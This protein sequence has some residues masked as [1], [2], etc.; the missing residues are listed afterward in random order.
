MSLMRFAE[1]QQ[2]REDAVFLREMDERPE[3]EGADRPEPE[4]AEGL[5]TPPGDAG[6]LDRHEALM[7]RAAEVAEASAP[8]E[9]PPVDRDEPAPAPKPSVPPPA[10]EGEDA[11]DA[12]VINVPGGA[13]DAPVTTGSGGASDVPAA[14]PPA[15]AGGETGMPPPAGVPD[16]VAPLQLSEEDQV[17]L[18][19]ERGQGSVGDGGSAE[20]FLNGLPARPSVESRREI[21]AYRRRML[22]DLELKTPLNWP[23]YMMIP[24]H[25]ERRALQH[26]NTTPKDIRAWEEQKLRE[27]DAMEARAKELNA[28]IFSFGDGRLNEEHRVRRS[29]N[30]DKAIEKRSTSIDGKEAISSPVSPSEITDEELYEDR[31]YGILFASLL[32]PSPDNLNRL[33]QSPV[34]AW[35]H[36]TVR[37]L[38]GGRVQASRDEIRALSVTAQAAQVIVMEAKARGWETLRISGDNEFCAAVKRACKEQG[39]GAIITRRGPLGLG[40]FSRPEYIMPRLPQPLGPQ[41]PDPEQSRKELDAPP[42]DAEAADRLL[43]QG[44]S[45]QGKGGQD[46]KTGKESPALDPADRAPQDAALTSETSGTRSGHEKG[47]TGPKTGLADPSSARTG[48][49][50]EE[51]A[52]T[53]EPSGAKVEPRPA[54]GAGP[55]RP[56]LD[57]VDVSDPTRP[58]EDPGPVPDED[59]TPVQ[60]F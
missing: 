35:G 18:L 48:E 55:A 23:E 28:W 31:H 13:S 42:D 5:E 60:R 24:T 53:S 54:P 30:R 26:P 59:W 36:D 12:P 46:P 10:G 11:S 37:T 9:E 27:A 50:P 25:E 15:E 29:K 14:A 44:A 17:A 33:Q 2:D 16:R 21:R 43:G 38:D 39:M 51:E 57:E 4:G 58:S 52:P 19:A 34:A 41:M 8:P 45:G 3:L 7:R 49:G 56:R 47:E 40:P 22:G 32:N 6:L 1:E 20:D